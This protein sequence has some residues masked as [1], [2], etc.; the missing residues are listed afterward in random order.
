MEK[1]DVQTWKTSCT[2]LIW[3]TVRLQ[4]LKKIGVKIQVLPEL[5]PLGGLKAGAKV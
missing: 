1:R 4:I 2:W 3:N 5:F